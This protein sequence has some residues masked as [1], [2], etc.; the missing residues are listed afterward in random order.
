MLQNGT[1]GDDASTGGG[2]EAG[3]GQRAGLTL[4]IT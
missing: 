4:G 2:P 3:S 1:S